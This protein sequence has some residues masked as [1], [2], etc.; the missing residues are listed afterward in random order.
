MKEPDFLE[1]LVIRVETAYDADEVV[2]MMELSLQEIA[3]AF[4]QQFTDLAFNLGF[5][6][7]LQREDDNDI[8]NYEW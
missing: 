5:I 3:E 8:E 7:E 4:P 6:N 1:E 2:A